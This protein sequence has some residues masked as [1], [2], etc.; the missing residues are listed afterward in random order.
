MEFHFTR[1]TVSA[2]GGQ[3]GIRAHPHLGLRVATYFSTSGYV[4]LQGALSRGSAAPMCGKALPF[5]QAALLAPAAL[6][7]R[8]FRGFAAPMCGKAL[9]FHQAALLTPAALPLRLFRGS[10]APMC[11]KALPFQQA[12]YLPPRLRRRLSCQP[13]V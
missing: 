6:P 9:P 10:A 2:K 13:N 11:G 5:Q 4:G 7:L 8:L 1:A 12:T 3:S